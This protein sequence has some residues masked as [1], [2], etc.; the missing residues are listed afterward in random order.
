MRY[1]AEHLL[2]G[3]VGVMAVYAIASVRCRR[4]ARRDDRV[5]R[6]AR[7]LGTAC[8]PAAVLIYGASMA[9][10]HMMFAFRHFAP[11]LA[12]RRWRWRISRGESGRSGRLARGS[13]RASYAAA[14]RRTSDSAVHALQAEAMYRRSL[15]GLGTLGEYAQQGVAGICTRLYSG[16]DEERA[17]TSRLTGPALGQRVSRASGHS[18][19][20]RFRTRIATRTFS[21]HSCRSAII[22]RRGEGG[23]PARWTR[24]ESACRLHPRVHT[25]RQPAEALGARACTRRDADLR[26]ADSFQRT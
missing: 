9:T 18:P 2:I 3:G 16:D 4:Q 26:A 22:A 10:V 23:E 24:V 11:Y 20:A 15:Q 5:G 8:R 6:T 13:S 14:V 1:M 19:P 7:A 12:R 21:K 25:P 17:R